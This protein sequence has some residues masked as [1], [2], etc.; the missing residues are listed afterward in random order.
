MSPC[1][2]T[3]WFVNS[4]HPSWQMTKICR[5]TAIGQSHIAPSVQ[6]NQEAAVTKTLQINQCGISNS[7]SIVGGHYPASIKNSS[8]IAKYSKI[9]WH[10][11]CLS[12]IINCNN[13]NSINNS[14]YYS[15]ILRFSN[16]IKK[17]LKS[18]SILILR[19]LCRRM[20][21]CS[22]SLMIVRKKFFR[23]LIQSFFSL[24]S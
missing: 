16:K 21:I 17:C 24:K 14:N 8:L 6:T 12:K 13:N 7:I 23:E 2:Y 4:H 3:S 20:R 15:K 1:S 22:R 9:L 5:T 19:R 10:N 11:S 18:K